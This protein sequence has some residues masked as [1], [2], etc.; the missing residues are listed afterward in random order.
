MSKNCSSIEHEKED[1]ISYCE[2]CKVYMC[3]KCENFHSKLC[4][5]HY[6][7]KI[8]I[9]NANELFTGFCKEENHFDKLEYFCKT[10][11]QLCCSGCIA[12]IKRKGKG[13]HTDCEVCNIEDIKNEKKNKLKENIESLEKALKE[14]DQL[15]IKIKNL[16]EVMTENKEDLKIKIQKFF[17]RLRNKLIEREE[18][19]LL[20]VED[21]FNNLY[22]KEDFLK[23][24]EKL[25]KEIKLSIE[26]GKSIQ[27]E[28]NN[29]NKLN[30]IINDCIN[31][32]NSVEKINKL[33]ENI[34]KSNNI[35]NKKL[36]FF[37]DDNEEI[38]KY[39]EKIS[40][41]GRIN[42]FNEKE[43]KFKE[44]QEKADG[45][46]IIQGDNENIITKIG[47]D[48]CYIYA[49]GKNILEKGNEYKWKIKILKSEN[50]KINIGVGYSNSSDIDLSK[51]Y[52]FGW[53][54]YCNNLKLYSGPPHE[55]YCENTNLKKLKDEIIVN[56][57]MKQGI[58]TFIIGEES[59]FISDIPIEQNLVPVVTLYNEGDSVQILNC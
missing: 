39:L 20:E 14:T 40:L 54:L 51:A 19:L 1:A 58:L 2:I 41:F 33:N 3:N 8:N 27:R 30:S 50:N 57:D 29:D 6:T 36:K 5:N 48:G 15:I 16:F 32:E 9:N 46:Y 7:Y 49:R 4:K 21:K 37:P 17:T 52:E 55:Y 23:N 24:N 18:E 38:N 11:N 28:W 43:Y 45:K 12:K 56:M 25:P 22:F 59:S 44:C 31:I 35:I 47:K 53:F 10:H 34:N 13:Q 42:Y 26:K